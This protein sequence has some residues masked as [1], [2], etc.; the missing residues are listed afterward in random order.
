MPAGVRRALQQPHLARARGR[1]VQAGASAHPLPRHRVRWAQGALPRARARPRHPDRQH[2]HHPG[3]GQ[4]QGE[5]RDDPGHVRPHRGS[6]GDALQGREGPAQDLAAVP[7]AD[8]PRRDHRLQHR[9]LRPAVPHQPRGE[10]QGRLLPLLGPRAPRPPQDE[11]HHLQLQ[12]VRHPR[13]QGDHHRGAGPIRPP[14]GD[15]ARPQALVLLAQRGVRALP[16]G[17]EGGRAPQLHLR[18]AERERGDQA[19]PRGLL[20]QGR[21]PAAAAP[22]QADVHVQL[23]RD[24]ARDG[25][26]R[27]VPAVPRAVHQ[28]VQPDPAQVPRQEPARA[29]PQGAGADGRSRVRG[30]HGAG[31]EAGVLR[32]ARGDS[33][34]RVPVPEYHDGAQPLLQ[35]ARAARHGGPAP[36]GPGHQEPHRGHLREGQREEGHPARDSRGTSGGAQAGQGGHQEGNGPPAEG[37]AGREAARAQSERQLGVWLHGRHGGQAPVPRD[38]LQCDLLR[39]R[40]DRAHEEDG[41]GALHDGEGLQPH[42]GRDIWG[43]GQCDGKFRGGGHGGGHEAGAGGGGHHLRHLPQAH[44]A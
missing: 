34:L 36:R 21:L 42:R 38:L 44:Q 37:R 13:E 24:G 5:E 27:V 3:P 31:R 19:P 43:H 33:R 23:H 15:P 11:G 17:A 26:A 8:G 16:G 14:A 41:G 9:Q 4:A 7:H 1:V 35:H 2:A 32:E 10:A 40:D 22:R 12:G 20:P 29:Q 39:A 6:R 28:G 18:P 25:R 30:G